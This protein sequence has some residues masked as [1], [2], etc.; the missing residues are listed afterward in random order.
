M[1]LYSGGGVV[2]TGG[3]G[4]IF[5]M[6]IGLHILG[7]IYSGGL[8]TGSVLTGFYGITQRKQS[9]KDIPTAILRTCTYFLYESSF[10]IEFVLNPVNK[11]V[12]KFNKKEAKRVNELSS[13]LIIKN[14]INT[15]LVFSD[16]S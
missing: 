11:Y 6:L 10:F 14:F 9:F 12:I 1:D 7:D 4:F 3:G 15:L 16:T 5:G 8:Y 2:Y 13:K